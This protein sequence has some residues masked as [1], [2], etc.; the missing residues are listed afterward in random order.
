MNELIFEKNQLTSNRCGYIAIIGRSNVGKS[1]LMNA[2]IGTKVSITSRKAQTT[3]HRITGIRTINTTQ[4]IYIDTPGFQQSHNSIL[5]NTLNRTVVSTLKS[6][7]II[8]LVIELGKFETI[9]K[10]II[11]II[12][13]NI[14]CILV[15]NKLDQN[16]KNF[17]IPFTQKNLI[18]YNFNAIIPVSAKQKCQLN[19][20]Q[21]EIQKLLPK[22]PLIFDA[23]EIT[24]CT[25]KFLISEIIRE[26]L[27]YFLGQELPYTSI[28]I[29]KN[30]EYKKTLRRIFATILVKR[31][32][33][34]VILI[35]KNGTRLKKIATQSRLD[36]EKF[37]SCCVYLNI[38]IKVQPSV[39]L[40]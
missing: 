19:N 30:I 13:S 32:T 36:I 39:S 4:F 33:H 18:H 6:A 24:N 5:N 40:I 2:L 23:N 38:W 11:K 3:L 12:P 21:D 10:Q 7:D 9:D 25:E 1:T 22:N 26:K 20:L 37:F 8:L 27:F 31:N 15:I 16:K 14:P 35:G 34:K 28:V 29:I 17:L